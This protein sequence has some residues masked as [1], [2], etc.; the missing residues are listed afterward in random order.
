MGHEHANLCQIEI[1]VSNIEVSL[2]FYWKVFGW[3]KVPCEIAGYYILDVPS[4]FGFGVSL[5]P[6]LS[7]TSKKDSQS[8]LYFTCQNPDRYLNAIETYG[9]KILGGPSPRPGYG[10]IWRFQD[11][12]GHA[13]GLFQEA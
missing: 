8:R 2:E 10:M 4:E 7:G 6:Q 1:P 3:K 5:I 13:Y 12:D 11:P 9:G